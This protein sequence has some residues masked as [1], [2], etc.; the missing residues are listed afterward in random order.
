MYLQNIYVF[1]I[2][3]NIFNSNTLLD[4]F[5]IKNCNKHIDDYS[6][7]LNLDVCFNKYTKYLHYKNM[8][9]FIVYKNN[10][11]IQFLMMVI[12]EKNKLLI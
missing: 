4:D 9:L 7:N 12:L 6:S 10:K 11:Y 5:I 1:I 2:Y 3:M 8:L